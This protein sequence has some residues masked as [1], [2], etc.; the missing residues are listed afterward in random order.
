MKPNPALTVAVRDA[1]KE[2]MWTKLPEYDAHCAAEA[3]VMAVIEYITRRA[4]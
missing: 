3:A 1:I 4:A 2:A